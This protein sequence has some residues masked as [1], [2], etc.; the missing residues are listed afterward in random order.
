MG[1]SIGV[2]KGDLQVASHIEAQ[3]LSEPGEGLLNVLQRAPT[4][5]SS[6]VN[7]Y[8]TGKF[9]ARIASIFTALQRKNQR[10]GSLQVSHERRIALIVMFFPSEA[11][12]E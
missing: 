10:T 6:Q 5:R 2:N 11:S 1:Y 3:A 7:D 12:N 8:N 4:E 9:R